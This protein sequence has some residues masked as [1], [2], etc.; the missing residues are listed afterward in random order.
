MLEVTIDT[1]KLQGI[2]VMADIGPCIYKKVSLLGE[3]N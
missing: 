2:I 3:K 1:K